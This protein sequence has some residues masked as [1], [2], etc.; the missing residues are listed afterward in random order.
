M[1]EVASDRTAGNNVVVHGSEMTEWEKLCMK[2]R[3]YGAWKLDAFYKLPNSLAFS[4]SDRKTNGVKLSRIDRAS[5]RDM[6]GTIS[7]ILGI[8]LSDHASLLIQLADNRRYFVHKLKIPEALWVG[9][10]LSVKCHRIM[11]LI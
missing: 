3:I 1:I 5:L 7:I 8:C 6:G 4:R 9:L 10:D 2:L 11:A